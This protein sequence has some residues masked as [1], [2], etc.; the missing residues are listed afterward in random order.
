MNSV[1]YKREYN[2][3]NDGLRYINRQ[4]DIGKYKRYG[5]FFNIVLSSKEGYLSQRNEKFDTFNPGFNYDLSV[6]DLNDII[7]DGILDEFRYG[8]Y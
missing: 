6:Q 3:R 1:H 4:H 7:I 8:V 5:P 2:G